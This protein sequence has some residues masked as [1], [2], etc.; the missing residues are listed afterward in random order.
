MKS[1]WFTN[2]ILTVIACLLAWTVMHR[3][4]ATVFAQDSG[5]RYGMEVI[6]D[7]SVLSSNGTA[8]SVRLLNSIVGPGDIVAAVPLPNQ[9]Q[10]A[11]IFR[12]AQ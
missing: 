4:A 7:P 1:L 5:G 6:T 8:D 2:F 9:H 3:P 11:I 10:I 12:R